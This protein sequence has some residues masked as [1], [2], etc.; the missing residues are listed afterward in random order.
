MADKKKRGIKDFIKR[1][2]L[3]FFGVKPKEKIDSTIINVVTNKLM[4]PVIAPVGYGIN[5]ETY[6]VSNMS[7]LTSKLNDKYI[8]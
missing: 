1:K 8:L 3:S 6:K 7:I 5:G 2:I 4:I